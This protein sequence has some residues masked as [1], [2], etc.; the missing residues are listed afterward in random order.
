MTPY[1][2]DYIVPGDAFADEIVLCIRCGSQ[3]MGLTYKEMPNVNDPNKIVNVA[4]KK[5]RGNYRQLPAVLFRKGRERIANIPCCQDCLKEIDPFRDTDELVR[6]IKRA[7][8]I[9]ARWVGAPEETIEGISR[10]YIDAR[11]LRRL[12][13]QEIIEGKILQEV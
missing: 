10:Q 3:I 5:K 6:Q 1:L 9:E 4:H 12:N 13:P 8:Q 2:K 11:F 7:M